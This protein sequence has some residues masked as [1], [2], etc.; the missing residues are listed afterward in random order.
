MASPPLGGSS[1]GHSR[2]AGL[3][4]RG[5]L[6]GRCLVAG[7]SGD[8]MHKVPHP[9]LIYCGPSPPPHH[10]PHLNRHRQPQPHPDSKV[11]EKVRCSLLC[12]CMLEQRALLSRTVQT[13]RYRNQK[14]VGNR[15]LCFTFCFMFNV[16]R[17]VGYLGWPSCPY[18]YCQ[19]SF[20]SR[21]HCALTF[22]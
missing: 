8:G 16:I 9:P 6:S 3:P 11:P 4:L 10:S 17:I 13:R 7:V 2:I 20:S 21:V 14:I 19:P 15:K 18:S 12:S 5:S 22:S 1:S